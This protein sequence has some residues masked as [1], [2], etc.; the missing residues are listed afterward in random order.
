MMKSC[1]LTPRFFQE[2]IRNADG[3]PAGAAS[4]VLSRLASGKLLAEGNLKG[5]R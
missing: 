1:Q 2:L 4:D 5:K 3:T